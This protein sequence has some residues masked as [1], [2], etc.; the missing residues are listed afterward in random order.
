MKSRVGLCGFPTS[1]GL[2]KTCTMKIQTKA[3]DNLLY[4]ILSK[5]VQIDCFLD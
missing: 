5:S 4:R 1:G 2:L 3:G